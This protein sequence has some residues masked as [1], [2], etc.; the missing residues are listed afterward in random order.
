MNGNEFTPDDGGT[1]ELNESEIIGSFLLKADEQ[2]AKTVE[3]RVCDLNDPAACMEVWIAF[4]FLL[5]LAAWSD[6]WR[7]ASLLNLLLAPGAACVQT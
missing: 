2:L 6:M 1:S 7:I 3:K 4:S 5:F